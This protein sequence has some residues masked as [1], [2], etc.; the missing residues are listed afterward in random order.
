MGPNSV[1]N[2]HLAA[3]TFRNRR[4]W[5]IAPPAL[6]PLVLLGWLNA[7]P[8]AD[9]TVM[10]PVHHFYVVCVATSLAMGLSG[11]ILYSALRLRHTPTLALGFA[12]LSSAGF[13]LLHGASTPGVFFADNQ[14]VVAAAWLSLLVPAGFMAISVCESDTAAGQWVARHMPAVL[15]AC[16]LV[17]AGFGAVALATTPRLPDSPTAG[18]TAVSAL[19]ADDEPTTYGRYG[20]SEGAKASSPAAGHEHPGGRNEATAW[21][22]LVVGVAGYGVGAVGYWRR[23][24]TTEL[25]MVGAL[26]LSSALSIPALA[27]MMLGTPW[28]LSWWLYHGLMVAAFGV[29][30]SAV[31]WEAYLGRRLNRVIEGMY[32]LRHEVDLELEHTDTIAAMAAATEAK[33]PVTKGHTVRVARMATRLGRE[34]GLPPGRVQVLARAGLLHDVGKLQIPDSILKKPGPLTDEEFAIMKQHPLL[35][36][37]M[38]RGIG[39]LEEEISLLVLHHEKMDGTGYPYGWKGSQIPFEARILS[40]ADFY[41]S[42]STDRP[43]HKAL[44]W[45][46]V[47]EMARKVAGSHL[48][49]ECV[50]ALCRLVEAEQADA[51][52]PVDREFGLVLPYGRAAPDDSLGRAA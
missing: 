37:E 44:E 30:S 18:A 26:S 48:D 27:S 5:V 17:M 9:A 7:N 23:Y 8:E 21:F 31:L 16:L 14:L 25:P 28:H 13:S 11:A 42:L 2:R 33:D 50:E 29:G 22:W 41:D 4:V 49:P 15:A 39:R 51:Q 36:H 6:L 19:T 20:G 1:S 40:V 38:L 45:M 46:V 10:I 3:G 32:A 12:F 35:R 52:A 47:L 34:M 24:L 43:Y